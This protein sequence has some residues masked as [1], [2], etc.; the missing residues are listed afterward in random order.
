MMKVKLFGYGV[1]SLIAQQT[2]ANYHLEN[3]SRLM[4]EELSKNIED[5]DYKRY[6]SYPILRFYPLWFGHNEE[7]RNL[8]AKQNMSNAV[9]SYINGEKHLTVQYSERAY[10]FFE[11]YWKDAKILAKENM[12]WDGMKKLIKE[13]YY[14]MFY[15]GCFDSYG[16]RFWMCLYECQ[17][18]D[19][20]FVIDNSK[21]AV[22]YEMMI[23]NLENIGGL[24]IR[25][26]RLINERLDKELDHFR[27][28]LE[29]SGFKE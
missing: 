10:H 13:E 27:T 2:F 20:T 24:V 3:F 26:H 17:K 22:L 16:M 12:V 23:N 9:I 8:I 28:K 14:Y 21:K 4:D 18:I 25:N 11:S 7:R 19:K 5:P 29:R 1:L 6:L 15:G